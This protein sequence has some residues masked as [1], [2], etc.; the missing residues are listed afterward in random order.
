[1]ER[2]RC[3]EGSVLGEIC[4]EKGGGG[5]DSDYDQDERSSA[6][7]PSFWRFYG[8]NTFCIRLVS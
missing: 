4:K 6:S 3:N 2:E 1:M 5:F 8:L 7:P